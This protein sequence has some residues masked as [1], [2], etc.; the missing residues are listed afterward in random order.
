MALRSSP[1]RPHSERPA[2]PACSAHW[3]SRS[4]CG[5][6]ASR[7]QNSN[8]APNQ[9]SK[10]YTQQYQE[11]NQE[12]PFSSKSRSPEWWKPGADADCDENE[13]AKGRPE[14]SW[15][16][17]AETMKRCWWDRTMTENLQRDQGADLRRQRSWISDL[18]GGARGFESLERFRIEV[19]VSA[20]PHEREWAGAQRE[21][22]SIFGMNSGSIKFR[23]EIANRIKAGGLEYKF[24]KVY[25]QNNFCTT[26]G[27]NFG[28]L[29]WL[30]LSRWLWIKWRQML[31]YKNEL[32]LG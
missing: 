18:E 5:A 25:R 12:E 28:G 19:R 23:F 11:A 4:Y 22:E 31:I 15:R 24:W 29:Q 32:K 26:L 9:D 3:S 27:E 1:Q 16:F 30:D 21:R 2:T 13:V 10:M 14:E 20:G 8:P 7:L 17:D 6:P